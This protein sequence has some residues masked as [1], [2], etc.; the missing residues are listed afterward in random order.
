V[1]TW[2]YKDLDVAFR[3]ELDGAGSRTAAA[4][5]EFVAG[6]APNRTF[7]RAF[8]WCAGPGFIGFALV[9]EGMC[10]HLCLADINVAAMDCVA[11]TIRRNGL[12]HKVTAFVSDNLDGL[13]DSEMFDV[14]VGNPPSFARLNPRHPRYGVFKD[15]LRPNDP[16]WQ[17]HRRFYREIRRHLV[18]GA[19]LFISEVEVYRSTVNDP[20][21]EPE[22]WDLRERPAI[23]DLL[24]MIAGSGLRPVETKYYF[25]GKKTGVNLYMMVSENPDD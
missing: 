18:P 13:P 12:E 10:Q 24:P 20:I 6:H 19:L 8:E 14:V 3:P 22:P 15:D 11:E 2:R 4:F 1:E 16:D 23:D 21:D 25:T 17:L 5:V 7:E 9:A